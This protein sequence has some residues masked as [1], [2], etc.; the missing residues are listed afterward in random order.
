M[1]SKCYLVIMLLLTLF[2][3]S[4]CSSQSQNSSVNLAFSEYYQNA[5]DFDKIQPLLNEYFSLIQ[6]AYDKSDKTNL[7]SFELPKE[8]TS[9]SDKL[10]AI[11]NDSSG[12]IVDGKT[13]LSQEYLARL[14]L[15]EPYLRM[16]VYLAEK[17]MLLSNKN[18]SNADWFTEVSTFL[19]DTY[20]KYKNE[21][22]K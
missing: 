13:N 2:G 4:S 15:L 20:D 16:E 8:F 12:A 1:K 6:N 7:E 9:I 21:T 18:T 22:K 19:T 11:S 3:L 5:D 10:L 14:Q 17:E